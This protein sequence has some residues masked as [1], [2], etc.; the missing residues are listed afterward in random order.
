MLLHRG[1]WRAGVYNDP[2]FFVELI[3]KDG[4]ASI[5]RLT[6]EFSLLQLTAGQYRYLRHPIAATIYTKFGIFY[7]ENEILSTLDFGDW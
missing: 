4:S 7:S 5:H 1:A 3:Y 6:R 2:V